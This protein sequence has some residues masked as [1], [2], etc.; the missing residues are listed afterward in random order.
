MKRLFLIM[1]L[2]LM[3]GLAQAQNI[4]GKWI[5]E[6]GDAQVEIYRQGDKFNGKIVWLAQGPETTDKHNPDA[7]LKSRKLIGVNI[8]S[9]LAK[10]GDK[11]EDGSIYNP[12]NGKSYKCKMWMEK[13]KLKVRGYLGPFYETQ[14]WTRKQ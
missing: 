3:T 5:T 6:A 7:K 1:M 12:K 13:D 9:N 8:L 11:W 14:T 2:A 4:L 10:K